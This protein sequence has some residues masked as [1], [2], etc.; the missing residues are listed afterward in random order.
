[1][2]RNDGKSRIRQFTVNHVKV[3]PADPA[4]LHADQNLAV[5]WLRIGNLCFLQCSICFEQDHCAH[6]VLSV[7]IG[8]PRAISVELSR[9]RDDY[10]SSLTSGVTAG[11]VS[12][13]Y[14]C[15]IT[16]DRSQDC[17]FV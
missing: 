1:M 15:C 2:S 17:T 14:S 11:A 9:I 10:S 3:G 7:Y 13:L 5:G 6:D 4:R 16:S 12:L 8:K